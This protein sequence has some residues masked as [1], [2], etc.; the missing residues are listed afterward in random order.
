[1]HLGAKYLQ[2]MS[3][4]VSFVHTVAWAGHPQT[5]RSHTQPGFYNHFGGASGSGI[6]AVR[7]APA[8]SVP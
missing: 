4:E 2:E 1:M 5:E 7:L 6:G 3:L 8:G